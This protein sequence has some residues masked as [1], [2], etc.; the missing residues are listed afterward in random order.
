MEYNKSMSAVDAVKIIQSGNRVFIYGSAATPVYI[1]EA[2][3]KRHAELSN[4]ELVSITTLGN[5][6]FNNPLYRE[7]FFLNSLFVSENNRAVVNSDHGDY[8]P[9]FLS[10]IPQLFKEKI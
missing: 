1:L 5:I 8:V 3:Q 4:V 2:L 7:S 9:I 6:D 10:Q